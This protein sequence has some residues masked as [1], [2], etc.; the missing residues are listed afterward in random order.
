MAKKA[1]VLAV[2]CA[3]A[4]T[5]Y[6]SDDQ[7]CL[8][9]LGCI[10]LRDCPQRPL[11][12]SPDSRETINTSFLFYSRDSTDAKTIP[13]Y[14]IKADTLRN[15]TF[16]ASRRTMIIVHGWTDNV[17][18]GRWMILMK[19]A[20]LR[21]GDFNVIL[22]DWTGGNGLPYTKASVNTRVVGAEIGLLVSKL[23]DTFGI[24]P[25]SVHAYGHS[26]GGHIVGY[27]GKWLNGTLGRITS[28]DPAEPLF[29]FCPPPARLSRTDA[30]FV[31]VVH[32]DST[33]FVPRFG[34]GMDLAVGDVDFYPNGGQRM[35][36]CDV[37]GRFIQLKDK[38]IF[39]GLRIVGACNHMRAIHYV[40]TF[41][42]NS[43][44]NSKCLPIAFACQNY[45]VFERGYCSD[46]GSDGSRCAVM[47]LDGGGNERE[48]TERL[49]DTVRMYFKTGPTSP[50]CLYHYNV[51]LKMLRDSK[52]KYARE[53]SGE[54]AITINMEG[55][56]PRSF[57][58]RQENGDDFTPGAAY[59]YLITS[60]TPLEGV[61]HITLT[62]RS[63]NFVFPPPLVLKYLKFTPMTA[64]TTRMDLKKL[65]RMFCPKTSA[66]E[67]RSTIKLSEEFC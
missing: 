5:A 60:D 19:D 66:V 48:L 34:L 55:E 40:T 56:K 26:L 52:N 13:G 62:Y 2:L 6:A 23:M 21:N 44:S 27:A 36:G 16:D 11:N 28:L 18:L 49:N 41:L 25:S 53:V 15:T 32:T 63:N 14:K 4:F 10:P 50:F 12:P 8:G 43:A 3:R 39:Q 9:E 57:E 31:E 29:E 33:S 37:K 51:E 47:S 54:V 42:E 64:I 46:C 67:S 30:Q 59:R 17:F 38:N 35:P 1:L 58:L 20:L 45:E 7:V 65:S 61:T 24:S 22:V